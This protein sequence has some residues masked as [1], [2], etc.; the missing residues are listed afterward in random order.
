MRGEPVIGWITPLVYFLL[1][2][3]VSFRGYNGVKAS[4]VEMR[5]KANFMSV[6]NGL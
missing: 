3:E 6:C 5:R 4:R 2:F 1:L